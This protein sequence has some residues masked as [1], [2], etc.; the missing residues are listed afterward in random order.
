MKLLQLVQPLQSLAKK[1]FYLIPFSVQKN[2]LERLLADLFAEAIEDG[3]LDFLTGRHLNIRIDDTPLH[4]QLSFD[5]NRCIINQPLQK[6][7]ASISG[8]LEEFILLASRKEDPDTLF[9]QRR[10]AIQGDTEL[11]LEVKNLLD[12]LDL[13]QLPKPLRIALDKV[14]DFQLQLSEQAA[15]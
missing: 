15:A 1:S 10:L 6:A 9:F 4:W 3:D 7:D 11:S 2:S 14:G 5:G 13:S 8:Q 12:T